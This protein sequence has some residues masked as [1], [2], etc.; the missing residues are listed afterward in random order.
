MRLSAIVLRKFK[1]CL[2]FKGYLKKVSRMLRR[3]LGVFT[4]GVSRKIEGCLKV[5]LSR[6]QSYL[7]EV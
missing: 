6:F 4:E 2:K 5:V 7:K 3:R 1:G